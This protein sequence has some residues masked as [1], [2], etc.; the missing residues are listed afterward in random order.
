MTDIWDSLRQPDWMT[1]ALCVEFSPDLFFPKSG[2][3]HEAKRVCSEC[4]VR[5]ECLN[6]AL[7][8]PDLLGVWG[9]TTATDRHATKKNGKAA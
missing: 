8:Q 6:F 3:A 2:P 1:R 7:D 4:S 5:N 9:G